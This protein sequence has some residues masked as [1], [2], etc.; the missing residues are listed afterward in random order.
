MEYYQYQAYSIKQE[1]DKY[2]TC[3]KITDEWKE[4]NVDVK[5]T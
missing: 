2:W 5:I 4:G 1:D 3:K